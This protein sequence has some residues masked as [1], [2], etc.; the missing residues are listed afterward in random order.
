MEKLPLQRGAVASGL[1]GQTFTAGRAV[2]FILLVHLLCLD[3]SLITSGLS[4]VL[5]HV[6]FIT[7]TTLARAN[8][9]VYPIEQWH[10]GVSTVSH[11]RN[12]HVWA[13]FIFL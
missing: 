1:S 7:G 8:R 13:V 2:K 5:Q 6:R 9:N 3:P 10:R 12:P 4:K 11:I